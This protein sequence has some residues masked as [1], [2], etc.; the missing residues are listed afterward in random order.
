MWEYILIISLHL[1]LLFLFFGRSQAINLA[2]VG[3]VGSFIFFIQFIALSHFDFINNIPPDAS[4]YLSQ[5]YF[6]KYHFQENIFKIILTEPFRD[7]VGN[8][9]WLYPF[10]LSFFVEGVS[11][12]QDILSAA[13]LNIIFLSFS[14]SLTVGL[15]QI[16]GLEK[17]VIFIAFLVFTLQTQL[18]INS[19]WPLK[20]ALAQLIT[21]WMVGS[22]VRIVDDPNKKYFLFLAVSFAVLGSIRYV[23]AAGGALL[24]CLTA[25]RY[26]ALKEYTSVAKI[27]L[28]GGFAAL[29]FVA[30]QVF[31]QVPYASGM[32]GLTASHDAEPLIPP[33]AVI[34]ELTSPAIGAVQSLSQSASDGSLDEEVESWLSD[35]R[36]GTALALLKAVGR[37]LFSPNPMLLLEED[38]SIDESWKLSYFGLPLWIV[39]IF[40]FFA[41]LRY[42]KSF[43]FKL[44][45]V[46]VFSFFIIAA[47]I[48]FYGELSGRQRSYPLPF[49]AIGS[50]FFFGRFLLL[51][52]LRN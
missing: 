36:S 21:L 39:T 25:W 42:F 41:S 17:I 23:G 15:G 7:I 44:I 43:D 13:V 26:L 49:V 52:K 32:F 6:F 19:L 22:I 48:V 24:L 37:T 27:G 1:F 9:S 34:H 47:Y 38:F 14:A 45:N 20:D 18:V 10:I 2:L 29:L 28:S 30:I 50:A 31:P 4:G 46:L 12:E 35:F 11:I 16:L 5:A 51:R 40:G 3:M 33:V 8:K